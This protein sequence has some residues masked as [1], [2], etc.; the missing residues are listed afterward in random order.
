MDKA[1]KTATIQQY[2]RQEGDTG[3]PEVQVALLTKRIAHLTEHLKINRKDYST[4][5]GLIAMVNRRKKLLSYLARENFERY[6]A[7]CEELDI[8][9]K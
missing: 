4:Q 7:L 5:T 1:T 9:R 6:V 3:S 8:R 2:A